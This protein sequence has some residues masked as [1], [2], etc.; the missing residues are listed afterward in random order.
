MLPIANKPI[1]EWNLINAINAGVKDFVFVIGYKSEMVRNYFGNGEKWDVKIDYVNQRKAL[2]TAHAIG[3]VEKFVDDFVVLCGDTIFGKED[4]E[5]IV[6]KG[7]SMGLLKVDNPE[8]YGIVD[9]NEKKVLKIYEKVQN[10][11]SNVI[12][13]GIYHF[14]KKIFDFIKK[15]NTSPRGEFEITDSINMMIKDI[16]L[17]GIYLNE[18]RDTVYP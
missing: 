13:A 9:I 17:E 3:M 4:I 12:N 10:P 6:K 5:N 16:E 1:L 2:G 15:T 11:I 14:D 7:T 8:E 18:W